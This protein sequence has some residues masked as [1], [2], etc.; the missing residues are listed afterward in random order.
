VKFFFISFSNK[1]YSYDLKTN[2]IIEDYYLNKELDKCEIVIGT[3]KF[4]LNFGKFEQ[5][6][7]GQTPRRIKRIQNIND[8]EKLK[9]RGIAGVNV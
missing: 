9:I 5:S 3:K 6:V 4:K 2:I 8:I 7:K 1:I